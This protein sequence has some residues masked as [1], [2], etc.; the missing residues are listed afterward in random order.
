MKQVLLLMILVLIMVSSVHCVYKYTMQ[1]YVKDII[2]TPISISDRVGETIDSVERRQFNLFPYVKDFESATFYELPEGGYTVEFTAAGCKYRVVNHDIRSLAI[3]HSYIDDYEKHQDTVSKLMKN[4]RI[5]VQGREP[6]YE[7]IR[8]PFETEWRIEDYD[9]LA[10]P[11]TKDEIQRFNQRTNSSM[12]GIGCC[13][14]T[15][16]IGG[17]FT[18]MAIMDDGY[19][20]GNR[21]TPVALG[22]TG[23]V[24]VSGLVGIQLG[25][26]ID[27]REII[28]AI[29]KARRPDRIK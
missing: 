23:A 27:K 21:T 7:K 19:T 3:M 15:G 14:S 4:R 13:L 29:R 11:I 1:N 10:L 24:I 9:E 2:L 12:Y 16:F 25:S 17:L 20:G 22:C 8:D 26:T 28:K 18:L 6:I 5:I